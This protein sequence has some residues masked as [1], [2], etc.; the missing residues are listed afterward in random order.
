MKPRAPAKLLFGEHGLLSMVGFRDEVSTFLPPWLL[1]P[2]YPFGPPRPASGKQR[3]AHCGLGT[4]SLANCPMVGGGY[5]Y[6]SA[7]S[8]K[9]WNSLDCCSSRGEL[10]GETLC[11]EPDPAR[12]DLWD[13]P[14]ELECHLAMWLREVEEEAGFLRE[15]CWGLK[16]FLKRMLGRNG[17]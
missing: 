10:L 17:L 4:G 12:A 6:E 5:T 1:S 14:E 3:F 15:P 2:E 11:W 13:S 7:F 16:C 8:M 9:K